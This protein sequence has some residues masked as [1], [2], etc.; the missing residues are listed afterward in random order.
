MTL[1][2]W[3]L[4][5]LWTLVVEQGRPVEVS[6]R[7]FVTEWV[8]LIR[9]RDGHG[10][11]DDQNARELVRKREL[12]QKIGQARL[13]ND[14]LMRQWGGASGSDRLTFRWPNVRTLLND[15][16]DGR[17]GSRARS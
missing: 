1:E 15:I 16:A 17:E 4:D 2:S 7:H 8:D 9:R 10:L 6:T 13:S 5:L 11:E 14:R 3:N 12:Y